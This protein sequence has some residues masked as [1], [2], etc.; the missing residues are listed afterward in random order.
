MFFIES[1]LFK[2]FVYND[3]SVIHFVTM[4][5]LYLTQKTS[6]K[7]NKMVVTDKF[8]N[9]VYMYKLSENDIY[10]IRISYLMILHVLSVWLNF[11]DVNNLNQVL[12]LKT[13]HIEYKF[14]LN[15]LIELWLKCY[16]SYNAICGRFLLC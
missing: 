10:L 8:L 14:T 3:D 12:G 13:L 4:I 1:N 15:P 7:T 16:S 2:L 11:S 9:I 6:N 5:I